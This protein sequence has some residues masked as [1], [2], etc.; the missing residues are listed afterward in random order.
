M[1]MLRRMPCVWHW[2]TPQFTGNHIVD[3]YKLKMLKPELFTTSKGKYETT[4]ARK[5]LL[6]NNP[7]P[8]LDCLWNAAIHTSTVHPQLVH[9][10]KRAAGLPVQ[11]TE[12]FEI[13]VDKLREFPCCIYHL[14][15]PTLRMKLRIV[16]NVLMYRLGWK[17]LILHTDYE[18]LDFD[19]WLSLEEMPPS[20]VATYEQWANEMKAGKLPQVLTYQ[21]VPHVFVK[22]AIPVEGLKI[23]RCE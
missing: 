22:G 14:P 21:N 23:I 19:N 13:P 4:S 12:Y 3:L 16:W 9:D 10:A 18:A 20:T 2:R 15:T 6:M 11:P 17:G 1:S 5:L 7:I 8:P